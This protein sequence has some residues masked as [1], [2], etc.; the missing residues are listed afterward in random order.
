MAVAFCIPISSVYAFWLLHILINFS[1]C[2]LLVL[3]ILS[4]SNRYVVASVY[5]FFFSFYPQIFQILWYLSIAPMSEFRIKL[6][7]CCKNCEQMWNVPSSG[8]IYI[9]V[10]IS[11]I[12]FCVQFP[13][14]HYSFFPLDGNCSIVWNCHVAKKKE[15]V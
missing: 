5:G 14:C 8:Y 9:A 1:Y 13:L 10:P 15:I 6:Y 4:H 12:K 3:L 11:M 2:L 7:H